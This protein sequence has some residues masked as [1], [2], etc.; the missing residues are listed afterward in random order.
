MSLL[1]CPPVW[2]SIVLYDFG[3]FELALQDALSIRIGCLLHHHGLLETIAV[4][5]PRKGRVVTA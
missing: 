5:E 4:A 2:L 1:V 3:A